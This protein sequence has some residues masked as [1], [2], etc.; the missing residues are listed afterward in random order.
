M[1]ELEKTHKE[2]SPLALLSKNLVMR[3]THM[4]SP[5]GWESVSGSRVSAPGSRVLWHTDLKGV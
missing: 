4:A 2:E 1:E 3:D 5:K